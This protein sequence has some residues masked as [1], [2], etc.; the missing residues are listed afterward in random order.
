MRSRLKVKNNTM[1]IGLIAGALLV[2]AVL[3][4]TAAV[5][6]QAPRVSQIPTV[7]TTRPADVSNTTTPSAETSA[8]PNTGVTAIPVPTKSTPVVAKGSDGT[9]NS[10]GHSSTTKER[11]VV[12]PK[13]RDD[14]NDEGSS[15]HKGSGSNDSDS[16]SG[17]SGGTSSSSASGGSKGTAGRS[18]ASSQSHGVSR[19][20]ASAS[21]RLSR[22]TSSDR[23]TRPIAHGDHVSTDNTP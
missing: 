17:G 5:A 23:S 6:A 18:V 10:D 12:T 19:T 4:F 13:I 15:K 14:G 11:E 3:A 1:R 2:V 8:A 22:S 20:S 16:R 9:S 21:A 7:V